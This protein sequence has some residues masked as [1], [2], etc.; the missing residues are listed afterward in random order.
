MQLLNSKQTIVA[1][2]K[3]DPLLP[4]SPI[5]Q[6]PKSALLYTPLPLLNSPMW[7][8]WKSE[9]LHM[10]PM[11]LGFGPKVSGSFSTIIEPNIYTSYNLSFNMFL[12]SFLL[13]RMIFGRGVDREKIEV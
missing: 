8:K 3:K 13:R 12:F 10:A 5:L 2:D 9:T 4:L 7:E 6:L 11:F 1:W